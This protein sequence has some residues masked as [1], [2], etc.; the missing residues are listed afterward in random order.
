LMAAIEAA[1]AALV[2]AREIVEAFHAM[3]RKK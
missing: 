1:A 2:E 3:I